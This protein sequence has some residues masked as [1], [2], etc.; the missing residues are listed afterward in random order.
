VRPT[1]ADQASF[2]WQ[3]GAA[4]AVVRDPQVPRKRRA[5][6]GPR[7]A[8]AGPP[9]DAPRVPSPWLTAHQAAA[10]LGLPSVRALYKRVERASIPPATVRRWGRQFRF[11]REALDAL[12]GEH[13]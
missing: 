7:A 10:Y 9:G 8:I 1:A 3:P 13:G 2:E 4:P 11:R 12:M 6:N 5:T